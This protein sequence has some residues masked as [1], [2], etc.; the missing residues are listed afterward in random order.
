MCKTIDLEAHYYPQTLMDYFAS[1]TEFPIYYPEQ[2][3]LRFNENFSIKHTYKMSHLP[4]TAEKRLEIMDANGV[5]MQVLS[6]SPGI[7]MLDTQT[8][9]EKVRQANDYVY[10]VT[11]KY[12]GRFLGF[13]ALQT[14]DIG[15]A[16]RELERC[17]KELGFVGWLTFSNYG[18]SHLDDDCF[19]PLLDK[20]AELG[21]VIYLHPTHPVTGRL[22]GLGAELAGSP[23]GFGI[24]TSITTMRLICK[25]VFDRNPG[26]KLVLGHLGEVFPFILQRMTLRLKSYHNI[27]PAINKE[28]PEYYFRHNIYV[29]TSGVYSH[30]AFQLT[31]QILGIDHIMLGSDYPY[32]K[33]EDV[34]AYLDELKLSQNERKMLLH[35][36]AKRLFAGHV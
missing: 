24:D 34:R 11:K 28:L 8:A 25:G 29:T 32:E 12:P 4:E 20:A 13:A 6:L 18:E 23:F 19:A 14:N 35:D 16:C 27:A 30:E 31:K 21:A 15:E 10:S 22:A 9:I 36:N 3:E 7:E 1:R 2:Y 26:M 17:V 5:D 33:L